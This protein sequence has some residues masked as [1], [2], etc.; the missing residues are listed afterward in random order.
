MLIA[1]YA[2]RSSLPHRRIFGAGFPLKWRLAASCEGLKKGADN[3]ESA[4]TLSSDFNVIE[5]RKKR[6]KFL[7]SPAPIVT[8]FLGSD[9]AAQKLAIRLENLPASSQSA[10]HSAGTSSPTPAK[11]VRPSM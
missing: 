2:P 10:E 3:S 7:S 9:L 1:S 4:P 6:S 11:K 8:A 5:A